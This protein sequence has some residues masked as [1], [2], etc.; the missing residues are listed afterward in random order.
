MRAETCFCQNAGRN[1]WRRQ[2]SPTS[3]VDQPCPCV[4]TSNI[5]VANRTIALRVTEKF[6]MVSSLVS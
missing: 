4:A 6:S 2:P 1:A 5:T 3:G